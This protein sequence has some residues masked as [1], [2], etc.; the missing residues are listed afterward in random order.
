MEI[1]SNNYHSTTWSTISP[2]LVNFEIETC[3][4]LCCI[5]W[6]SFHR[7]ILDNFYGS[8][9]AT[10]MYTSIYINKAILTGKVWLKFYQKLS[11]TRL[12]SLYNNSIRSMLSQWEL[13]DFV[14]YALL[15]ELDYG[16]LQ[17]LYYIP[18]Y[19]NHETS[20]TPISKT[21]D[22]IWTKR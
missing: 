3:H 15:T 12:T 4:H 6:H 16:R 5:L 7:I 17:W 13:R 14:K 1:E 10:Y 18:A 20:I 19:L 11:S 9:K 22:I 2:N 21:C 8:M